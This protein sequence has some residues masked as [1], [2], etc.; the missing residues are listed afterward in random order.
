MLLA[1][2]PSFSFKVKRSRIGAQLV[3]RSSENRTSRELYVLD[4][5]STRKLPA[6]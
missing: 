2:I 6:T 4:N 3:K 1:G 5:P